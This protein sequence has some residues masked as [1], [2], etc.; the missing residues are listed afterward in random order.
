M[1]ERI[2]KIREL[3]KDVTNENSV[4]VDDEGL[5]LVKI[6]VTDDSNFL[7]PFSDNDDPVISEETAGFL[8]HSVKHL[9]T[10]NKLHIVFSGNEI[11]EDEQPVYKKAIEN[12][13]HKELVENRRD[14]HSNTVRSV[15][16]SLLGVLLFSIAIIME[17]LGVK[18]LWLNVMDVVAWVF[19]WEA[20]DLF[21]LERTGLRIK[22][23]INL[24]MLT[25][26]ITF[27]DSVK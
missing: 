2:K 16:L 6:K 12:Y 26:K 3:S 19:V 11:T 22:Q 14:I 25:A 23:L 27:N 18:H 5:C 10:A 13:F 21:F 17:T 24:K 9:K 1:F 8:V 7:S 4:A 20:V 15:I